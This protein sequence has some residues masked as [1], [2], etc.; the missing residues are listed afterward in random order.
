MSEE[1]VGVDP[2]FRAFARHA[3]Q[4]LQ[5][6]LSLCADAR[7]YQNR[8]LLDLVRRNAHTK[9]GVEHGFA[10]ID[11]IAT[12][13]RK[14]PVRDYDG[15][16]PWIEKSASGVANVLTADD[17]VA[18]FR[19]SGTTGPAKKVPVTGPAIVDLIRD[20][21]VRWGAMA[22]L[23]PEAMES[24]FA[25]LELRSDP[26]PVRDH[27]PSG[28][29]YGAASSLWLIDTVTAKLPDVPPRFPR[30]APWAFAPEYVQSYDDL[31]YFRLRH[32][33]TKPVRFITAVNPSTLSSFGERLAEWLPRL[34]REIHD[35]LVLGRPCGEGDVEAARRLERLAK[36]HPH[37]LPKH[38][39][40]SLTA[41]T[42]W[43]SASASLYLSQLHDSYGDEVEILP[44]PVIASEGMLSLP[45][46]RHPHAGVLNFWHVFVEFVPAGADVKT[47]DPLLF[48][49]LEAGKEYEMVLTTSSGLYRYALGDL[50]RIEDMVMGVPRIVFAGRRGAF[51]SFTGEKLTES[52]VITAGTAAL[53]RAE[54]PFV[55]FV[56]CPRWGKPPS[57]VLVVEPQQPATPVQ[58]AAL[59]SAFDDE[60]GQCN[61]E[62]PSKR[63]SLRLGPPAAWVV[64]A[65]TFSRLLNLRIARGAAPAQ[66]KISALQRDDSLLS[67]LRPVGQAKANG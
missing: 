38:V 46:D 13:R 42:C 56:C 19:T 29:P 10:E 65:G 39:W 49:E 61:D 14:V 44:F 11:N 27:T 55:S 45:I 31:M 40:P 57:Y 32:A 62:Y 37:V 36:V 33:L 58:L 20:T 59:A 7:E 5:E 51:S 35:G 6:F 2:G 26:R 24:P 66:A 9:F 25:T 63:T 54:M 18:F 34:V 64:E 1:P 43:K 12:Y 48:F 23:H 41:L 17:P 30:L 67:D 22:T 21:N 28:V 4:A 15:L 16:A 3:R 60:L 47:T 8:W 53:A 52:Q 50:V